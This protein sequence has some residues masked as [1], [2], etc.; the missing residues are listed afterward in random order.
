MK[1]FSYLL[2]FLNLTIMIFAQD[3][4]K[5]FHSNQNK[6]TNKFNLFPPTVKNLKLSNSGIQSIINKAKN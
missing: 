2:I 5:S 3:S 6:N 4:I 1:I